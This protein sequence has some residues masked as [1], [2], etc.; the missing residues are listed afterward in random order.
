MAAIASSLFLSPAR[1]LAEQA[2]PPDTPD[3]PGTVAPVDK[4]GTVERAPPPP[5]Y[6]TRVTARPNDVQKARESAE[7]VTVYPTTTAQ[8]QGADLGTV[9]NRIQGVSIA[10]AGGLGSDIRFSLNGLSNDQIRI[11]LDGVPLEIAG[12]A[13]GV[14]SI[15][16]NLVDRVEIHRGVV[17][18]RFGADALGG[19]V[20]LVTPSR[21]Y[22]TG[23]SA[24]LQIGSFSTYRGT[25]SGQYRHP[26]T[27]F[28]GAATAFLDATRNNYKVDVEV[29]DAQGQLH[30]ATVPLFHNRYSAHGALVDIGVVDRPWARRLVLRGFYSAYQKELQNNTIMTIPYGAVRYGERLFGASLQ[31]VQ[32]NALGSGVDIDVVASYSHRITDFKDTSS[33]VYDWFGR[34]IFT[35]PQPGEIDGAPH[36][37][38]MKRDSGFGRIGI[39]WR[40][41]A[42]HALRLGTS[43][44][45]SS[46]HGVTRVGLRPGAHDPLA[47]ARTLLRVV[48]GAEYQVDLG[49]DR[50]QNIAFAKHYYLRAAA[51]EVLTGS[52]LAPVRLAGHTGGTGDGLRVR[53]LDRRLYLKASYEYA[54]R[55]P[56]PTEVFGDGILVVPNGNLIPERSHN[57][58]LSLAFNLR[59]TPVGAFDG[60]V[61]GFVRASQNLIVLLSTATSF[62]YKNLYATRGVGVEGMVR[63]TSPGEWVVVEA[64][65][66][67]QDIRNVSTS[68]PYADYRGDRLP[69]MPWLFASTSARAQYRSL[70]KKNDELALTWYT[71][72]VHEFF[73]DWE[74]I[75]APQ[76]KQVVDAQFV[77]ALSLTY[78]LRAVVTVY[79]AFDVENLT[80]ARVFDVYGVQRP[81]RAFY[82]KATL[83]F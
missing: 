77:H 11:F 53:L 6:E 29:P 57:A 1:V 62:S 81:G 66:T 69:N 15:P 49:A 10:R 21:Y 13:F 19:A 38:T 82:G 5:R 70:L 80:N 65:A 24:S 31:Y 63:W 58:N 12:F 75:G 72:Y 37:I 41:A 20:N 48:S 46:S 45:Y 54:T 9:L 42:R 43:T 32:P 2:T 71:R 22:R 56:G 35:R 51:D 44:T 33:D 79:F 25:A 8:Q 40:I 68:G 76:Y 67:Y 26:K 18:I 78:L 3:T 61:N 59:R 39:G 47:A 55:L 30:D 27:G 83:V 60:E 4:V 52:V 34:T 50:V 14:A 28:F 23:T 17:P 64:S 16:V 7:A 36:D 74:S 73:R